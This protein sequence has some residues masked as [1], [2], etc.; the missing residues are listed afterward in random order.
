MQAVV[1]AGGRGTRLGTELPKPL[2]PVLGIP[3]LEHTLSW[4]SREGIRDV[5]LCTGYRAKTI[6]EVIGDG[7]R[8]G[9]RVRHAVESTPL[10]TGG[11]VALAKDLLEERFIVAYGDVLCDVSLW[12]MMRA[13]RASGALAT[14]AVHPNSHPFDSD[15]VVTRLDGTISRMVRKEEGAGVEVGALCS[16]ALYVLERALLDKT[17]ELTPPF[18]FARDAFPKLLAAGETLCA[19]RTTEYLKDMGTQARAARVEV[20][21]A[22]GV[23]AAMRKGARRSA[24]LVDR[25]GV[26]NEDAPFIKSPSE[27]RLLPGAADALRR[28]NE[29]HVLSVCCT[30]QPVVARGEVTEDGLSEIH[31]SLEGLLGKQGAWLDAIYTCPHHPHRGFAGERPELKI[32][33]TCRKPMPGLLTAAAGELGIALEKS[34]FVGDRTTDLVA[35]ERAGVLPV[36]ILTGTALTDG[37][38]AIAPEIPIVRNMME[39]ASFFLD[40]APSWEPWIE[41]VLRARVVLVGGPSRA[42][43]TLAASSLALF[44]KS[45]G[46]AVMRL[47]CDRFIV[48]RPER[49]SDMTFRERVQ[50]D[51]ARRAVED[52]ARG[53]HVLV[54]SYDPFQR[55]RGA[56]ALLHWIGEGILVVD[57]LL[58]LEAEVPGALRVGLTTSEGVLRERRTAFFSWKNRKPGTETADEYEAGRGEED[59]IVRE[60]VDRADVTF[61]LDHGFTLSQKSG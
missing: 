22:K 15:R 6:E 53:A 37:V 27:L 14:L 24:F 57:G 28:M 52:I 3:M 30:N 34:V 43:K 31:R 59:A 49:T 8:F 44:L 32:D 18:D 61:S 48:P 1:L 29:A 26:L 19:Y 11:A 21:L 23:P 60:S 56:P 2:Y 5:V 39:A 13:H 25:D 54:P 38:F 36:G 16:A 40:L 33:C 12:D 42:G 51:L 7:A 50:G 17:A 4:L 45:R 55:E 10:G 47:S 46:H 35:A 41:R 20:E 58:V 9:L